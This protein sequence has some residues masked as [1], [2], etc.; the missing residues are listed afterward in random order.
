MTARRAYGLLYRAGDS[1][2]FSDLGLMGTF[3]SGDEVTF[4]VDGVHLAS[5]E[6]TLGVAS[7]PEPGTL[8]LLATGLIGLLAY[9]WRKRK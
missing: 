3:G 7:V 9:A 1:G 6:Y 2:A 8:V 5:G 4:A